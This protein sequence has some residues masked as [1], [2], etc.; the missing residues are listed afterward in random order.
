MWKAFPYAISLEECGGNGD[1]L[2]H[3]VARATGWSMRDIR[4]A[5]A[6]T[7]THQNL[8]Q[9]RKAMDH[10]R[11]PMSLAHV[12]YFVSRPGPR[13]EGTDMALRWLRRHHP[14]FQKLGFVLLTAHGPDYTTILGTAH[15]PKFIVLFNHSN[16][17]WQLA[18]LW[19]R[20]THDWVPPTQ[21]IIRV[22]QK[23]A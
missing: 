20:Q 10:V 12:R 23:A 14:A 7:L 15:T 6:G 22:I 8:P 18:H 17:H 13:F 5:L 16:T 4:R 3:C 1:C 11:L 9:F 19:D 21:A 2:F